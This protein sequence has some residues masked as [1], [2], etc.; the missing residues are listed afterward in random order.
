MCSN[1]V[2]YNNIAVYEMGAHP[3][4][5]EDRVCTVQVCNAHNVIANVTLFVY[6]WVIMCACMCV[7]VCVCVLRGESRGKEGNIESSVLTTTDFNTTRGSLH[8]LSAS[9]RYL[10]SGH[11]EGMIL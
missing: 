7:C 9:H 2:L 11:K 8:R 6:L 3:C 4:G 5:V 10:D 1:N